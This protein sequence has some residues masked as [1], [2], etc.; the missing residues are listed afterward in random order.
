MA[1]FLDYET[2]LGFRNVV[3]HSFTAGRGWSSSE[4]DGRQPRRLASA[5]TSSM[6]S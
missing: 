4:R 1:A 2:L 5:S 6:R 3:N